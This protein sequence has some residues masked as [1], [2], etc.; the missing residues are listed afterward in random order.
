[1][2]W[3]AMAWKNHHWTY[4]AIIDRDWASLTIVTV[5]SHHWT[6]SSTICQPS[7]IRKNHHWPFLT[8][9]SATITATGQ[10]QPRN[11]VQFHLLLRMVLVTELAIMS[12]PAIAMEETNAESA[13]SLSSG[14]IFSQIHAWSEHIRETKNVQ[15]QPLYVCN[16]INKCIQALWFQFVMIIS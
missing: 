16:Y 8:L 13:A 7:P 12:S 5:S 14:A 9:P 1:M 3:L 15:I 4:L 11:L 6:W 2:I 10:H